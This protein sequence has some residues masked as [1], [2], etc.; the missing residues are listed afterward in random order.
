MGYPGGTRSVF[1]RAFQ[2]KRE[3]H[4]IFLGE[5]AIIFTSTAQRPF[6]HYNIFLGNLL[7][8]SAGKARVNNERVYRIMLM[9][10]WASYNT[11]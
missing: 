11:P 10:P 7:E 5:K 2:A 6:S 9:P 8:K 1:T 4:C 3:L